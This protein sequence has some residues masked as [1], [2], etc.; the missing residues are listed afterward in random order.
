ML[1]MALWSAVRALEEQII[2]SKRVIERSRKAN[3]TRAVERFEKRVQEAQEH[4]STIR[5]LL[6]RGRK[7]DIAGKPITEQT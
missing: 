4:S 6:L 2:L 3:L 1:E 5:Q 7:G